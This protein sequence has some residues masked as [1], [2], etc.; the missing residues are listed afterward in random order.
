MGG[1]LAG[2]YFSEK[3]E[4]YAMDF[5]SQPSAS[6]TPKRTL[7]EA[8]K[9]PRLQLP[10]ATL[11]LQHLWSWS[12]WK[13]LPLP[14]GLDRPHIAQQPDCL[15]NVESYHS[16]EMPNLLKRAR[17]RS[18]RTLS[19]LSFLHLFPNSIRRSLL[20][21][22]HFFCVLACVKFF[23]RCFSLKEAGF[24]S[25]LLLAAALCA[26]FEQGL[27]QSNRPPTFWRLFANL[28][29]C[30][31]TPASSQFGWEQILLS[32]KLGYDILG[33]GDMV[34]PYQRFSFFGVLAPT[35]LLYIM[36]GLFWEP[37]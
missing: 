4:R 33:R 25:F 22:R 35:P 15:S 20:F 32:N 27:R 26:R 6:I 7:Q 13:V 30:C 1:F 14:P 5:P 16:E 19:G 23:K 17:L 8:H 29:T 34:A 10:H 24:P 12:I 3:R 31:G 28:F 21:S 36:G 37:F 2:I 9:R 18:A 11:P